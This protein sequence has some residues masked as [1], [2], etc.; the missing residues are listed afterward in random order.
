MAMDKIVRGSESL[1]ST[2]AASTLGLHDLTIDGSG[3]TA[4]QRRFE[5]ETVWLTQAQM[6]ELFQTTPQNITAPERHLRRGR[7]RRGGNL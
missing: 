4:G 6:A 7:A 3:L 5:G 2:L 1:M